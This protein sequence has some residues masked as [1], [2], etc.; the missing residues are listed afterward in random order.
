MNARYRLLVV[1]L[2]A[3]VCVA[4][5]ASASTVS[6]VAGAPLASTDW[7]VTL[8]FPQFNP[9]LG[10]LLS[11]SFEARDSLVASFQVENMSTSSG[12]TV[13]DS[14]KAIIDLKRPDSSL[15]L[16]VISAKEYTAS[17]PVYDGVLDFGG[18][19]GAKAL[20]QVA[21]NS[22][23]WTTTAAADLTLFTGVGTIGLP[24]KATG[25]SYVS[26]TA[27][28][29]VHSVSTQAAAYV[30]VTYTYDAI[31]PAVSASW[32]KIKTLYR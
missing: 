20:N 28:N 15:L 9:A 23:S 17:F 3:L 22:A 24:C 12:N 10:T 6:Y 27:G 19:S 8:S 13:R 7:T 32:G 4:S 5:A 30:V 14:S 16:E 21:Y 26:D 2:I 31:V 25:K 11:V 18:T 1:G 29:V